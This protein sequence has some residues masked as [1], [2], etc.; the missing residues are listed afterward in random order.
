L[1]LVLVLLLQ[2]YLLMVDLLLIRMGMA[3]RIREGE[4]RVGARG[5]GEGGGGCELVGRDGDVKIG[6]LAGAERRVPLRSWGFRDEAVGVTRR[7]GWRVMRML[8]RLALSLGLVMRM[9]LLNHELL[10]LLERAGGLWRGRAR[11]R[12]RRR[13]PCLL[14]LLSLIRPFQSEPGLPPLIVLV[15]VRP[16]SAIDE[17]GTVSAVR[18]LRLGKLVSSRIRLVSIGE[19]GVRRRLLVKPDVLLLQ[20]AK[21]EVRGRPADKRR[22]K[23]EQVSTIDR[24]RSRQGIGGWDRDRRTM[25]WAIESRESAERRP[26]WKRD[27][28]DGSIAREIRL[29]RLR[30]RRI[31]AYKTT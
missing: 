22:T 21:G 11:L 3:G 8:L 2:E 25:A 31:R 19:G 30:R 12:L 28:A 6:R 24:M 1:L 10:L 18:V 14:L 20:R 17:A 5:G 4:L 29:S 16:M 27:E 15:L 7:S 26:I 9:F 13:S 23:S